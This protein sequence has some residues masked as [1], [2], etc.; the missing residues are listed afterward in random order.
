VSCVVYRGAAAC[1]RSVYHVWNPQRVR[2]IDLWEAMAE[3]GQ[4][5]NG[6]Q[7][8]QGAWHLEFRPYV[9]WRDALSER[10]LAT[11]DHALYPLLHF[12]L[13]DLPTSTQSPSLDWRNTRWALEGSGVTCQRLVSRH[14]AG[15]P[16]TPSPRR[17]VLNKSTAQPS[18][19]SLM[20]ATSD[21][22]RTEEEDS[23][24]EH[25]DGRRPLMERYLQYLCTVGFLPWPAGRQPSEEMRDLAMI[26]RSGH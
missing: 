12:V 14:V 16:R 6:T 23:E 20:T 9:A 7:T 26:S 19:S 22:G 3:F 13:D 18:S 25:E 24:N 10:T 21:G 4:P 5:A 8:Q 15:K 11:D 2:F 17:H 1:R